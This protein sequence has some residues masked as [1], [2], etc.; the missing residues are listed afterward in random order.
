MPTISL[1]TQPTH[2]DAWHQVTAPGGYEWWHFD[3]EDFLND[4]QIVAGFFDGFPFDPGYARAYAR[5]RKNPTH[6]APP[7]PRQFRFAHFAV[8]ER[9]ELLWGFTHPYPPA[10]FRARTDR[11]DL[12]LGSSQLHQMDDGSLILRLRGNPSRDQ[13]LAGE[14]QF[15]PVLSHPPFEKGLTQGDH[16]RWVIANPLCEVSGVI[17][18]FG[19]EIGK[20]RVI[21][22]GGRGYHD[23]QYGT[24]P[25]TDAKHWMRGRALMDEGVMAFQIVDAGHALIEADE[26]GVREIEI[27]GVES[28]WSHFGSLRVRFPKRVRMGQELELSRPRVVG[29]SGMAL[30]VMYEMQSRGRSGKAFC[31]IACPNRLGWIGIGRMMKW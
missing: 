2:A 25:M 22:F 29:A 10:D 1:L 17:E 19:G 4:R 15:R 3:A 21:E 12:V 8:Y 18:L 11:P 31:E 24:R 6:C 30:R 26:A 14:L 9:G 16:Y 27:A 23:H 13:T 28:E 20:P 5:F 7:W